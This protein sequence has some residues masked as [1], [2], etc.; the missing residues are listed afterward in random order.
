MF[1]GARLLPLC[2][3]PN[4]D[5]QG[6]C[7]FASCFGWP[8]KPGDFGHTSIRHAA[9]APLSGPACDLF[10]LQLLLE[11]MFYILYTY[12]YAYIYM[13]T[14]NMWWC[15]T[16]VRSNELALE[17]FKVIHE[18]L[19]ADKDLAALWTASGVPELAGTHVPIIVHEDAVPH[20]AGAFVK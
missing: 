11:F 14:Y 20:F 8:P 13:H 2:E 9:S 15:P 12:I 3:A 10:G 7:P 19:G 6:Q 1:S 5:L 18:C 4:S 17:R 16:N